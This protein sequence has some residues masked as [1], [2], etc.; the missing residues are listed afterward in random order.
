MRLSGND[1]SARSSLVGVRRGLRGTGYR[2]LPDVFYASH[3]SHFLPPLGCLSRPRRTSCHKTQGSFLP[4]VYSF[5]PQDSM[6]CSH[7]EHFRGPI[8]ASPRIGTVQRYKP[9][10]APVLR[11][12]SLFFLILTEWNLRNNQFSI[13][14]SSPERGCYWSKF[15]QPLSGTAEA[16]IEVFSLS[17][18]LCF[19][20]LKVIIFQKCPSLSWKILFIQAHHHCLQKPGNRKVIAP[21]ILFYL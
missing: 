12:D 6:V 20:M 17:V 5:C 13:P 2:F 1:S 10:T 4:R 21:R 16:E 9:S 11:K 18:Q 3:D 14:L 15:T 19:Y 8:M 7:L